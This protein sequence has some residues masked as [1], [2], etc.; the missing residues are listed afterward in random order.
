[1]EDQYVLLSVHHK[2]IATAHYLNHEVWRAPPNECFR[3]DST[4]VTAWQDCYQLNLYQNLLWIKVCSSKINGRIPPFLL[5]YPLVFIHTI[6]TLEFGEVCIGALM[7]SSSW[8]SSTDWS[9]YNFLVNLIK[10]NMTDL[11]YR[12]IVVK[13]L[14][15]LWARTLNWTRVVSHFLQSH[16]IQ[17]MTCPVYSAEM[18]YVAHVWRNLKRTISH[19]SNPLTETGI[20]S[21]TI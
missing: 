5:R 1:M 8:M 15:L 12:S 10:G 9:F 21:L 19:S 11:V 18:N 7:S 4:K 13:D 3:G 14:L 16:G 20:I 6:G 2:N 17:R